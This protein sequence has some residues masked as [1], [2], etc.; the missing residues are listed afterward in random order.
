MNG[1]LIY[2]LFFILDIKKSF[3]SQQLWPSFPWCREGVQ[4]LE[5]ATRV[6][7][8]P[9]HKLHALLPIS[10]AEVSVPSPRQHL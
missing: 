7:S 8:Y 4:G 1:Y 5:Q 2:F 3:L 6:C 9:S 10:T